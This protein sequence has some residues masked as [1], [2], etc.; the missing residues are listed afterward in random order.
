M[1]ALC[2]AGTCAQDALASC[3]R[4]PVQHCAAREV[5]S[6]PEQPRSPEQLLLVTW[7]GTKALQVVQAHCNTICSCDTVWQ[8]TG[9]KRA[10]ECT[11]AHRARCLHSGQPRVVR[12]LGGF[13][14]VSSRSKARH[15]C[16]PALCNH[17][18]MPHSSTWACSLVSSPHARMSSIGLKRWPAGDPSSIPYRA[19]RRKA[20]CWLHA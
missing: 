18:R 7:Q 13:L 10:T 19:R 16:I 17:Q 8:Y 2:R 15:K 9:D 3:A 12:F 11:Y 5:P 6:Q 14:L 4:A 20:L 1:Q